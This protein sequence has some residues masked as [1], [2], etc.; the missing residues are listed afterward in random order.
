MFPTYQEFPGGTV[1]QLPLPDV[2]DLGKFQY[3]IPFFVERWQVSQYRDIL[4]HD[5]LQVG[6]V[7]YIIDVAFVQQLKFVG[8]FHYM[9]NY[10][11]RTIITWP[12][13]FFATYLQG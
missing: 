1:P 12:Q 5:F 13:L 2:K 9:S 8:N 7:E 6:Y 10:M 11:V 4:P 3:Q